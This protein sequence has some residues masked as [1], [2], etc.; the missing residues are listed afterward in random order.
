VKEKTALLERKVDT[1]LIIM[2]AW[3]AMMCLYIY[4]DMYSLYRPGQLDSM[5]QGKMGFFEVSQTS[6]FW[7][8]VLMVI[9]SLMILVSVLATARVGRIVNIV[10]SANFVLVNIGNLIG[11]AW[12]YYYLFGLVELGLVI[13]I[14]VISL[15]W[16]RQAS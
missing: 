6:L 13:F 12:A 4:C 14:F 15:R 8:G 2:A 3:I 5:M 16:P 7:A 1:K 11:E 9:P 10:V